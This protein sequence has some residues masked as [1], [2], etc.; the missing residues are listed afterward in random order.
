MGEK[1]TPELC[2]YPDALKE[3]VYILYR[4]S[5]LREKVFAKLGVLAPANLYLYKRYITK[6]SDGGLLGV[7]KVVDAYLRVREEEGLLA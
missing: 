1:A 7:Y 2:D 4:D 6:L 5:S 3:V